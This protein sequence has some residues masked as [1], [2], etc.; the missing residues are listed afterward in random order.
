VEA[1][2]GAKSSSSSSKSSY[3]FASP[4]PIAFACPRLIQHRSTPLRQRRSS[5]LCRHLK[6]LASINPNTPA[7][8]LLPFSTFFAC[9]RSFGNSASLKNLF[10][11]KK[12][13]IYRNRTRII[14]YDPVYGRIH[15]RPV[16]EFS[17]HCTVTVTGVPVTILAP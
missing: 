17:A 5:Q 13:K 16:A 15:T 4:A 11:L 2:A 12:L 6:I 1:L 14:P 3:A 7:S 9:S 8:S 10:G